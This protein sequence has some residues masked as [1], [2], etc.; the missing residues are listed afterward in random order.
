MPSWKCI[1][2]CFV[3]A[4]A[5]AN[6]LALPQSGTY[7]AQPGG[8]I[9]LEPLVGPAT[10]T[11][12]AQAGT[13]VFESTTIQN[14]TVTIPP[15]PP[16]IVEENLALN[17]T[18]VDDD[19]LVL[20]S[21]CTRYGIEPIAAPPFIEELFLIGTWQLEFSSP[22]AFEW[23]GAVTYYVDAQCTVVEQTAINS[24]AFMVRAAPVPGLVGP[25]PLSALV[26]LLTGLGLSR[27]GSHRRS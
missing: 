5:P 2:L 11:V 20:E 8:L 9:G 6:A 10:L 24:G 17:G 16:D 18:F 15:F 26:A 7:E 22:T 12:D 27:L 19:T 3:L 21:I 4:V 23:T 25:A 1:A 14:V 13:A